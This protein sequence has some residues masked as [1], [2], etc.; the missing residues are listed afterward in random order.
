ME[1]DILFARHWSLSNQVE[2][3]L[4]YIEYYY[5]I[6]IPNLIQCAHVHVAVVIIISCLTIIL[7]YTSIVPSSYPTNIETYSLNST[8]LFLTWTPP[9]E[10][11]RNGIIRDYHVQLVEVNTTTELNYTTHE[12]HLIINDL[13]Q[14][15]T[16]TCKIAAITTGPGPFSKP[17]N[18]I[19]PLGMTIT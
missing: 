19:N 10:K 4:Y 7:L 16:Y 13:K 9:L 18:I 17:I 11:Y 2:L 6:I 15:V 12:P 5:D 8:S 1:W 3:A 14:D